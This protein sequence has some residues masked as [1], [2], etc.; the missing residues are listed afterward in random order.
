MAKIQVLLERET[1]THEAFNMF[2]AAVESD[3]EAESQTES[4]LSDLAGLGID[5]D[6]DSVPVPMF[7][8]LL[9]NRLENLAAFSSSDENPH[10]G[11]Q[12]SVVACG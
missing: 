1:Q 11:A 7:G 12:S 2:A 10:G 9:Q 8:D 6:E 3:S 5:L 4:L